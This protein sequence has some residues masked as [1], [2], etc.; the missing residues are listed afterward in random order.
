MKQPLVAGRVPA[1]WLKQLE[2]IQQETGKNQSELVREAIGQYLGKT[3][4]ESI[5]SMAR[6]LRKLEQQY[7]KL[8]QLV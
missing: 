8:A 7:K 4:P 1:S 3:D 6:R 5:A 2:Q